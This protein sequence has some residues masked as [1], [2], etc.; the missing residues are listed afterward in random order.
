VLASGIRGR[1]RFRFCAR[2]SSLFPHM[3]VLC[4]GNLGAV[5]PVGRIN[6]TPT[7][8]SKASQLTDIW[9]PQSWVP[10]VSGTKWG[11]PTACRSRWCDRLDDFAVVGEGLHRTD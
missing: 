10:Y 4:R 2:G 6:S 7:T 9:G 3:E 8:S 1:L 11:P 5:G